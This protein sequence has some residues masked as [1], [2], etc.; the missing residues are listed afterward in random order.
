[1]LD[2]HSSSVMSV[3]VPNCSSAGKNRTCQGYSGALVRDMEFALAGVEGRRTPVSFRRAAV[4]AACRA[5]GK[6]G[7]VDL[8]SGMLCGCKGCCESG[9]SCLHSSPQ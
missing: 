5:Q 2:N 6:L 8:S 1:M 4:P 7:F 3:T 9:T